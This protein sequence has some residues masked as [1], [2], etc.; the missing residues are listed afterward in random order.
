MQEEEPRE[1]DED[2]Q[3]PQEQ[4]EQVLEKADADGGVPAS[5]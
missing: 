2:D 4:A 1:A 3:R 5:R